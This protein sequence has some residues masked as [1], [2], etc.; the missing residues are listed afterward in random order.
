MLLFLSFCFSFLFFFLSSFFFFL[1]LQT[2]QQMEEKGSGRAAT[3]VVR[4]YI[5][6]SH[7]SIGNFSKESLSE[8]LDDNREVRFENEEQV[9]NKEQ[10][11]FTFQKWADIC[12]HQDNKVNI[13]S[14]F[15]SSSSVN[16]GLID[17]AAHWKT[18]YRTRSDAK[19]SQFFLSFFFLFPFF[20]HLLLP[21]LR[22][23]YFFFLFFSFTLAT[24]TLEIVW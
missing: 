8:L 19:V 13:L 10:L 24:M 5:E 12:V 6:R 21:T 3:S 4:Q 18:T 2:D 7:G 9:W 17:V 23:P 11:L 1:Q 15:P 14:I 20:L 16:D 22:L